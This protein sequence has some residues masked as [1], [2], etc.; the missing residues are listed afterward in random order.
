MLNER[1]T[2]KFKLRWLAKRRTKYLN[3][4]MSAFRIVRREI[5][6][7]L[8]NYHG[9]I[10]V[11]L[12][13]LAKCTDTEDPMTFIQM[14]QQI[15]DDANESPNERD[16]TVSKLICSYIIF[17]IHWLSNFTIHWTNIKIGC[18]HCNRIVHTNYL[19]TDK[20]CPYCGHAIL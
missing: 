5:I 17:R 6:L 1:P 13:Y 2:T 11:F 15:I 4:V 19:F 20:V 7:F 18:N 14:M 10:D 9:E 12:K 3:K 8:R 16:A